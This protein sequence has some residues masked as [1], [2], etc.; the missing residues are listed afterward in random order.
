MGVNNLFSTIVPGLYI[1]VPGIERQLGV[2]RHVLFDFDG[3]LSLLRQGWEGVMTPMMLE[4]ICGDKPPSPEICAEV[5]AYI[6][7]STGIL[8]IRQMEWLAGVVRRFGLSDDPKTTSE[9]KTIYVQRILKVVEERL[10]YLNRG[11]CTPDEMMVHGARAFLKGLVDKGIQIFLASG[12]DHEYVLSEASSL[13][14]EGYFEGKIYGALDESEAND[15]AKVIE[16]ILRENHLHGNELLVVGD[17]PVEMRAAVA[18]GALTLGVAINEIARWGWNLDKIRRLSKAG[19]A[20]LVADFCQAGAIT[21]FLFQNEVKA[22]YVE[23]S[24]SR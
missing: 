20:M 9:Y 23:S 1:V 3:T 17:G 16:R 24:Y 18:A 13:R 14:I 6:E 2:I 11:L 7:Q 10:H 4:M 12:T 15:K 22:S 21:E 8:T 19:T 5:Q